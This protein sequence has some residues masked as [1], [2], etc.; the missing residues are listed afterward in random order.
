LNEIDPSLR[1]VFCVW[2]KTRLAEDG[3]AVA[4]SEMRR[5]RN[6]VGGAIFAEG[7][8]GVGGE[9]KKRRKTPSDR[10]AGTSPGPQ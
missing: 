5:K 4:P 6:A 9:E 8:A 7:R 1:R 10:C 2:V 3:Q